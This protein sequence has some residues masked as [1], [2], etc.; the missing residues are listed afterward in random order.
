MYFMVFWCVFFMRF[1]TLF[2]GIRSLLSFL[3]EFSCMAPLIPDVL[4]MRGFTFQQLFWNMAMSGSYLWCSCSRAC[5]GQV[6][7][8]A[9]CKFYELEGH[10]WGQSFGWELLLH[11]GCPALVLWDIGMV[12]GCRYNLVPILGLWS[13]VVCCCDILHQLGQRTQ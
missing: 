8:M 13:Q 4:V 12:G 11:I 3:M 1:L 9:I 7:V 2:Y 6:H 5:S 10:G